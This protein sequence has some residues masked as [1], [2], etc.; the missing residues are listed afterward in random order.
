MTNIRRTFAVMLLAFLSAATLAQQANLGNDP[1]ALLKQALRYGELYNWSDAAP[2]FSRAEQLYTE[3]GD[4]RNA[5]YAHLGRIRSTMEQLSLPEASEELGN[6][7]DH[8]PLLQADMELRLFCLIVRGDIDGELDAAPMRRDWEAALKIAS[9][10]GDKKW[11]NRAGGEIGF[12]M[13]LE[14]EM[15]AARQ[16]VGGALMGAMQLQ[17]TGAQIRYLAAIG[18]ALVWLNSYDEALGY[19]EKA[20]KIAAA[21]PD[22]GYQFIVQEGRLEAFKGMGKLD[23]AQQLADELIAQARARQ[24]RVKET[25]TLIT[26]STIAIA[27]HD[28]A[29]AI[30]ELQTAAELAQ[31]GGFKRLLADAQFYLA[32]IYRRRG[33]LVNAETWASVA[34]KSTQSGGEMYVL[35]RRMQS[36]AELQARQGKYQEAD[37]TYDRAGDILDTMIGNVRSIEAKIG[38]ITSMSEI[39]TEHFALIADHFKDTNK[40]YSVLERARGRSTSDLLMSGKPPDS[41]QE[42]QFERQVSRL[43]LELSRANSREGIREIRD[44][45]FVAEEG[46]W[47]ASA[48]SPWKAHSWETIPLERIREGLSADEVVLEYVVAEP[49]SYCL[50]ITRDGVRIVSLIGR[51]TLEKLVTA[52][53]NALKTRATAPRQGNELYAALLR[54]VPEAAKKSRF[55]VVPDGC[56]HLLPFDALVDRTGRYLVYTKTVTYSP[57]ASAYYLLNRIPS[58]L[59]APRRTLLGI[60]GIPYSEATGLNKLVALRGYSSGGLPTLP[61]SK[62]EILAAQS[63]FHDTADTLLTGWDA[64]ESAF[65]HSDLAQRAIIHLAVHGIADTKNPQR[66]AL[67]LLGD[68]QSEDDGILEANEIIQL[69]T[70]ADLVVLSA[71]DT[72][73]GRLQ[74]EEGIANLSRAFLL[75][76]ARAVVSTLWSVDDIAAQYLMKR[77]Y[78]HL[79]EGR[80]TAEAL[81]A[82][83]RD[84]LKTYGEHAIPHFW[85]SFKLEGIGNH[86]ISIKSRN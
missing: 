47:T 55:I 77:F 74:G 1:D 43:N 68:A 56:L 22:A 76:G 28:D 70:N 71:C 37:A 81:T 79:G 45:I 51:E 35:P 14:G 9:A 33:D 58:D 73:V 4:S 82:A 10:L 6:E 23:S 69:H 84:L 3:R 50:V 40:A 12:S 39:Y 26:A 66:A 19:L 54:D 11:Q 63:A 60:G 34:A 31:S 53:V 44:K 21:N 36:L 78:V 42:E 15:T 85:A 59:P 72:A 52:Y 83:K 24:K 16:R 57:S 67:I 65:K 75:A 29:Q 61:G 62:E 13:F 25:Q 5:L 48:S 86:S 32:D 18:Q 17:D 27:K 38:L 7:L 80:T 49:R 20:L 41:P 2:L 30:Q 64:T 46:R 8:N